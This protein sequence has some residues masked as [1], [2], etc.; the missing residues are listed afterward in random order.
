MGTLAGTDPAYAGL[1]EAEADLALS[2]KS[3]LGAATVTTTQLAS[4]YPTEEEKISL[5]RVPG[6]QSPHADIEW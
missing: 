2:K 4:D 1:A 6:C 5:R 3:G